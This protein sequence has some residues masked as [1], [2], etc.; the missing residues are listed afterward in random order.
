MSVYEELIFGHEVLHFQW[1]L[2]DDSEFL[3]GPDGKANKV[4]KSI[5]TPWWL[6]DKRG[7]KTFGV[8]ADVDVDSDSE[9]ATTLPPIQKRY[10]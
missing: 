7:S 8:I 4:R 6:D 10:R 9:P 1:D 2:E 3:S 5:L